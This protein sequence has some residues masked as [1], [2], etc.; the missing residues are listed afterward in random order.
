V[1]IGDSQDNRKPFRLTWAR[2]CDR[3]A[4]FEP[5]LFADRKDAQAT[6]Q[7][8][9]EK[10]I[11]SPDQAGTRAWLRQELAGKHLVCYCGPHAACHGDVL[12]AVANEAS[13]VT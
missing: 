9:F 7:L 3:P 8:A 2:W 6:A 12:L 4:W 13:P 11:R 5:E 1:R 10:W